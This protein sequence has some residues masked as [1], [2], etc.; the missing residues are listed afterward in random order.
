MRLFAIIILIF[1]LGACARPMGDFERA[2]NDIVHDEILPAIGAARAQ[3]NNEA[4][5]SLNYTDEENEMYARVWRF[6]IAPHTKDWFYDI[7]T[8]WQRTRLIKRNDKRFGIDRYYNHLRSQ[9]FLSS[10]VRY[11]ALKTDIEIDIKTLP[12]LFAAICAVREID[13]RRNIAVNSIIGAS[14]EAVYLVNLRKAENDEFINWFI[15]ALNYRYDS[16]TL[17]LNRLLIETPHEEAR[18]VDAKLSELS[19]EVERANR[20]DFCASQ[21]DNYSF[22]NNAKVKSRF[23]NDPFSKFQIYRK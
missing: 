21:F 4:I 22:G 19:I 11:N 7:V 13:K 9:N 1:L 12:K 8:E 17:A 15:V 23:I 5:S 10:K 6:L 14:E 20:G 3:N 18:L 16:Y 2:K